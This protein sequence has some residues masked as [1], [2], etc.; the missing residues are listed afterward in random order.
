M[1]S[2]PQQ[3]PGQG[4]PGGQ[5]IRRPMTAEELQLP[6]N[7]YKGLQ[8]ALRGLSLLCLVLFVF[9]L[10]ILPALVW[11]PVTYDTVSIVLMV[12]MAVFGLV[13]IG[14][15]ANALAM[16]GKIR[17]AMIDGTAI[18]VLAP[19]YRA[20]AMRKGQGWSIG[21]ISVLPTRGLD[22]ILVEGMPTRV[23][24]LP[25]LKAALSI[26]NVGLRHGARIMCPPNLD[27]MAV[28]VGMPMQTYMQPAG[29]QYPSC[30]A[31]MMPQQ[32]PDLAVDTEDLPPPP[33]PPD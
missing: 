26:N 31:A 8:N 22:G 29:S 2:Y 9:S 27:S 12:F 6:G 30:G 17:K 7:Y 33:P 5:V 11:D 32:S 20:G 25:R 23:L 13:A 24:C 14:M 3:Y 4:P 18:E 10:Y 28:L 15:S 16:R 19:A 21:P 1:M